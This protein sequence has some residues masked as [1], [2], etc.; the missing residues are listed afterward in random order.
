MA[1]AMESILSDP[2]KAV[3]MGQAGRFRVEKY[4]NQACMIT[5]IQGIYDEI[6]LVSLEKKERNHVRKS[7]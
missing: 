4:F 7:I 6:R 2:K 3:A 5:D 1:D